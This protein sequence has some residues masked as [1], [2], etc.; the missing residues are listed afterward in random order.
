MEWRLPAKAGSFFSGVARRKGS[1]KR[2]YDEKRTQM[3]FAV[4][5]IVMG[6]VEI[7]GSAVF[8]GV[9]EEFSVM[10]GGVVFPG[11]LAYFQ[12]FCR[13]N[14]KFTLICGQNLLITVLQAQELFSLFNYPIIPCDFYLAIRF[15]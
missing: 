10:P 4:C 8:P 11:I 6:C 15:L 12:E 9:Q 3:C 1:E 13:Q 5:W 7:D 14:S 2:K